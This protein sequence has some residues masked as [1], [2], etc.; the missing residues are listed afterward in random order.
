RQ[1]DLAAL[2][3]ESQSRDFETVAGF[4]LALFG[5]MPSVSESVDWLGYRL[6]VVDMDG[7]RIDKV[8]IQPPHEADKLTR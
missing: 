4:V 8:L 5:R 2:T 1:L 3:V 6:E 7:R